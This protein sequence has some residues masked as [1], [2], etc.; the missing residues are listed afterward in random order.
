MALMLLRNAGLV[1]AVSTLVLSFV[2][3]H[4]GLVAARRLGVLLAGVIVLWLL[5]ISHWVDRQLSRA[6]AGPSAAGQSSTCATTR[7]CCT[8][9]AI[10]RSP[11]CR[12]ATA[13]G[14]PSTLAQLNLPDEGLLVL[15][16]QRLGGK[17][18]GTPTGKTVIQPGDTL[19]IYGRT[20]LLKKL[21]QRPSG[22]RGNFQHVDAVAEQRD[23]VREEEELDEEEQSQPN[24]GQGRVIPLET[25]A[26]RRRRR[27]QHGDARDH[28]P[29][30][31][32]LADVARRK[33]QRWPAGRQ[34]VTE[35]RTAPRSPPAP[36]DGTRATGGRR[37][38]PGC[39]SR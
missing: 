36:P 19:V 21:D 26:R 20:E 30:Q 23:V 13:T 12:S 22:P 27:G 32:E 14:W 24:C 33:C 29:R 5:A 38:T 10:T 35:G 9:P 15:G 17:Y 7:G 11:S 31:L 25:G 39:R 4:D 3:T 6:I 34:T 1:T 28:P 16:L 18:L 8:W 2:G 37:A